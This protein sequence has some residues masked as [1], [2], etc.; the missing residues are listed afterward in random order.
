M[1]H[2]PY[3][4]DPVHEPSI[5]ESARNAFVS[6]A[7][8]LGL[9]ANALPA[10]AERQSLAAV[11]MQAEAFISDYPYNSAYSPRFELAKMDSRLNLKPCSKPLKIDFTHAAKTM[12]NTSL[13]IRCPAP[14]EWKITLPVRISV[15]D[16]VI[17]NK[18]PLIKGQKIDENALAYKKTDVSRL[19]QGYFSKASQ[20]AQL[21]AKRNLP[22]GSILN[23]GNLSP[24]QLVK[25]GEQVTIL[26]RSNGLSIK[27]TGRALQSAHIGEAV[28]VRNSG[29]NR[30]IEA[31]VS[32]PGQV[33]VG[34]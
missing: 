7:L 28:K 23:P 29:S 1:Q 34:F 12:G 6:L 18:T 32:A 11:A 13:S 30:V 21:Q 10:H 3:T 33:T 17:V 8:V 2:T 14:V 24:R 27:S 20:L 15:F 19:N 31:R 25:S 5:V 16:D 9:C 22:A 26:F 4:Q